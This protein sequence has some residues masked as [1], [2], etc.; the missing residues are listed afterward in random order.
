MKKVLTIATLCFATSN[1]F[2]A[3]YF[4]DEVLKTAKNVCSFF[5]HLAGDMTSEWAQ[6]A[7]GSQWE[8]MA[9]GVHNGVDWWCT[10]CGNAWDEMK[11]EKD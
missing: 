5:G 4:K 6:N 3:E 10:K 11:E 1:A 2:T 8:N 7:Q 9:N